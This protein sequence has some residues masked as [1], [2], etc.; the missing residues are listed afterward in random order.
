M[1]GGEKRKEAKI[2]R[3]RGS[4]KGPTDTTSQEV[5]KQDIDSGETQTAKR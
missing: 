5:K 1:G 4:Q 2:G 3:G